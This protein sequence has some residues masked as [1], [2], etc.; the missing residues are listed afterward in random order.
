MCLSSRR[1][2]LEVACSFETTEDQFDLK[3][4]PVVDQYRHHSVALLV[5]HV[6][7][8]R[9]VFC[10]SIVEISLKIEGHNLRC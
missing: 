2:F 3:C 10:D 9:L 7:K 1:P 5:E 8:I 4:T 6:A